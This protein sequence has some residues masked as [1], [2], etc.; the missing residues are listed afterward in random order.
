V[1]VRDGLAQDAWGHAPG[2]PGRKMQTPHEN[3]RADGRTA[4]RVWSG[5]TAAPAFAFI[6]TC[7]VAAGLALSCGG[8]RVVKPSTAQEHF[9][10][11]KTRF[12]ARRFL[13]ATDELKLLL[14]Q[15]P[16]SR[17]AEPAT[18]YLAKCYFETKEFPLA[19]VEFRKVLRDFPRGSHAEEAAFMLGMCAFKQ[20]RPAAYDQTQT[21]VAI[22]LLSSYLTDYPGGAFAPR[23]EEALL[24][25]RATLAQKLYLSG[26]LYVKMGD[27]QAARL[28]FQEVVDRYGDV[29][30]ADLALVG[31]GQSYEKERNWSMA[32]ETYRTV[33]ARNGDR[34]AQD[35]ARQRLKKVSQKTGS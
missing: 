21:E 8:A 32:A 24:E 27:V 33:L 9:D 16:G 28:C 31:V 30:W 18:H 15:Y 19:E 11:A 17:Y 2:A 7:V 5:A 35:A 6:L 12:D 10:R 22:Q 29:R 1:P 13:D 26:K 34:E 4:R 3:A 23:A 20:K 25:C 14:E